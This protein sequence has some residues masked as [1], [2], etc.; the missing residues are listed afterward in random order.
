MTM[1]CYFDQA[2]VCFTLGQCVWDYVLRFEISIASYIFLL[3]SV[4]MHFGGFTVLF[5]HLFNPYVK[6]NDHKEDEV[7]TYDESRLKFVMEYDRANPITSVEATKEWIRYLKDKM[8]NLNPKIDNIIATSVVNGISKRKTNRNFFPENILPKTQRVQSTFFPNRQSP[9]D[10][11][12]PINSS[13]MY[14]DK[15]PLRSPSPIPMQQI[16]NKTTSN[17][18]NDLK[19]ASLYNNLFVIN[20][21]PMTYSRFGEDDIHD[22]KPIG[23]ANNSTEKELLIENPEQIIENSQHD[24]L[25][26]EIPKSNQ[27]EISRDFSRTN[28][29]IVKKEEK[30]IDQE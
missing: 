4:I 5:R 16:H 18:S 28:S 11:Q 20:E 7:D 22:N 10:G 15:S 19:L 29:F 27:P 30:N 6:N 9:G 3:V 13:N 17:N 23:N 26:Y 14:S 21:E 25:G 24:N 8:P 12:P 2:L 1:M